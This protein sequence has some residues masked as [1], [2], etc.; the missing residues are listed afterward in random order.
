M[1]I[2]KNGNE[3]RVG[4]MV[5]F[6]AYRHG[7]YE[8]GIIEIIDDSDSLYIKCIGTMQHLHKMSRNVERVF[9]LN[10]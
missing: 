6:I 9:D 4:D 7:P 3:L 1:I 8:L 10:D 5:K 2:D